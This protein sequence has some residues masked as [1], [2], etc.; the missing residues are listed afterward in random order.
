MK[1]IGPMSSRRR[2]RVGRSRGTFPTHWSGIRPGAANWECSLRPI[3]RRTRVVACAGRS[4]RSCRLATF[5][6]SVR[7]SSRRS[8]INRERK[9]SRR[10][11][12]LRS[13]RSSSAPKRPPALR[14]TPPRSSTIYWMPWSLTSRTTCGRSS[15]AKVP[16]S[17][18][19]SAFRCRW[20]EHRRTGAMR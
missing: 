1:C 12:G 17:R 6:I 5:Y 14:P 3:L 20:H 11:C 4:S 13:S 15:R 10:N 8:S 9:P 7:D 2:S 19:S 16:R 18:F